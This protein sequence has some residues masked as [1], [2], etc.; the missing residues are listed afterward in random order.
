MKSSFKLKS[1]LR[2]RDR[3]RGD[4]H[5]KTKKTQLFA[6]QDAEIIKINDEPSFQDQV[7]ALSSMQRHYYDVLTEIV[8]DSYL[9]LEI[10]QFMGLSPQDVFNILVQESQKL[11]PSGKYIRHYDI[12]LATEDQYQKFLEN[13]EE[14]YTPLP[15]D[16]GT[17]PMVPP[18]LYQP[19][20]YRLHEAFP[21][22]ITDDD[23]Y[24]LG[25]MW[26]AETH[27]GRDVWFQFETCGGLFRL[28][29]SITHMHSRYHWHR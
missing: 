5:S 9:A 11:E 17:I 10:A 12:R 7:S 24:T 27:G 22:W 19:F 29:R 18:C 21:D 14:W 28:H 25:R 20:N 23:D 3:T 16:N 26:Y 4:F 15:L 2:R 8:E 1:S 6:T 13:L